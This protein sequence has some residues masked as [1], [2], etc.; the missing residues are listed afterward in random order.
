M[1]L[2][3]SQ[4][5]ALKGTTWRG[6]F[7]H[8]SNDMR[9]DVEVKEPEPLKGTV[10]MVGGTIMISKG[11]KLQRGFEID[12]IDGPMLAMR[13]ALIVLNRVFP[14]GPRSVVGMQ[15]VGHDDNAGIKFATPS[16]SASIGAPWRASGVVENYSAGAVTFDLT[17]VVPAQTGT[18]QA[19]TGTLNF[20]GRLSMRGAPVFDDRMSLADWT[21]YALGPQLEK[22]GEATTLDFGAKATTAPGKTI[23]DIRAAIAGKRQR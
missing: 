23:A 19:S 21:V 12:A 15:Q 4:D 7:D 13:L 3:F 17:M 14:H 18:A 9:I 8:Q 2:T 10:G 22:R 6:V 20:I 11:L 16:A 5:D 1:T